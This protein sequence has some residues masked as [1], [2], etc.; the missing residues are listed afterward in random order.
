MIIWIASYPKSGNTWIRSLLSSY[1]FS[2]DGKFSFK[3]LKNIEQFSSKDFLSDKLKSSHYQA[4]ISKNWIPSQKIINRDKKIHILKTHNALCSING[5]NFTD[6]FNT[7]AVI[8]IVRDPRNLITALS[9]HY[10][11]SLDEAFSFLTNKRKIIFP[12][13]IEN[14]EKNIKESGDFNFLG[15]WST[16]YQSWKNINF[17]PIKIIKY[18]DC[19]NDAQKVFVSTLNFLSKFLKFEF[20]KKKINS[21]LTSTSFENLSHKENNE[22]F[23]ESA[24]SSKTMK[25]IKFFNLGKKNN[26]KSLLDKKIVKKIESRFKNEMSELGYL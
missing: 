20:D 19:L 13:N 15:D 7:T 22:G 16:H 26:W 9:H 4:T 11:L 1:L 2:K 17:C 6:S 21:T 23:H 5:N 24:T 14:N 12:V 3:L 8:Y 25:K 10:E 18:E